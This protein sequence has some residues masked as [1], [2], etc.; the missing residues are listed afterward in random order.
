MSTEEDYL[1]RIASQLQAIE[2]HKDKISSEH[3]KSKC[4]TWVIGLHHGNTTEGKKNEVA[5]GS[6]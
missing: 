5:A 4:F 1:R 6:E 2:E 3:V